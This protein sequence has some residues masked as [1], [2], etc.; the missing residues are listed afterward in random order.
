MGFWQG[1]APWSL[2]WNS[3]KACLSSSCP[4]QCWSE[5]WF[6]SNTELQWKLT[7]SDKSQP[8]CPGSLCTSETVQSLT[9]VK[10]LKSHK[11]RK[12]LSSALAVLVLAW[13]LLTASCFP[14]KNYKQRLQSYIHFFWFFFSI[15]L[16]TMRFLYCIPLFE[17]HDAW[18]NMMTFCIL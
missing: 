9:C 10:M 5:N 2:R 3:V 14:Q 12:L 16:E 11:Q 6:Y 18:I 4:H 15:N 1:R 8:S 17:S 13:R 7:P